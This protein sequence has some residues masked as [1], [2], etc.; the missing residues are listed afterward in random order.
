MKIVKLVDKD[1]KQITNGLEGLNNDLRTIFEKLIE[2]T[3]AISDSEAKKLYNRNLNLKNEKKK[4]LEDIK[5]SKKR[6]NDKTSVL[7]KKKIIN[8]IL[9]MLLELKSK[10][11]LTGRTFETVRTI[12]MDIDEKDFQTLRKLEEKIYTYV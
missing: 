7:A 5:I 10:G 9:K 8:R 6:I 2:I 4:L 12:L 1:A 3:Y 11:G